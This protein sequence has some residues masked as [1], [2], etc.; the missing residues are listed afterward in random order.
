MSGFNFFDLYYEKFDV[1]VPTGAFELFTERGES[2]LRAFRG[3]L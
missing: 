2:I 3:V 1:P